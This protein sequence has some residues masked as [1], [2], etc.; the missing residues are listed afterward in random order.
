MTFTRFESIGAYLPTDIV[1][2]RE[3]VS[4][5]QFAPMFDLEQITGIQN[6][7]VHGKKGGVIEDSFVLA[8]AAAKDCLARSR[9]RVE[10]L[11]VVISTSI[12]RYKDGYHLYF[13]PSFALMLKRALG[14]THAMHFDLSNAC[15][16]MMTGVYVLDQMIKAGVVKNGIVIS[17]EC[18]TPIADTA[19]REISEPFDAQFG[20]LTVGDSGAAVVLDESTSDQD[21]IHYIDMMTCAAYAK[22]CIGMPSTINAGP[23]L[24]TNNLEMHKKERI[25]LWP[26]FQGELLAKMGRKFDDEKFDY[27][28]HHQVGLKAVNNFSRFGGALF[29]SEQM[30]PPLNVL[31]DF[32]NTASTSHF[33]VL[34]QHLKK[35]TLEKGA[36]LLLV[37][38][39]SGMVTGCVST[40][41]SSL[42]VQ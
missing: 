41:I 2:T 3:L 36:K 30:P 39:A 7:R 38:A 25:A 15:G 6:R 9:Y 31:E 20:S 13:E 10:D 27:I 12:T 5:M 29:G 19:V 26:K 28:V 1:S 37:P 16:G 18:I 33:V 17:G 8:A 4:R 42:E 24:Y 35:K 14:A 21:R 11:D 22:L 23:A 40:T 32:G 34:H